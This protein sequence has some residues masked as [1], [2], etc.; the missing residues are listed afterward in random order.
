MN[1]DNRQIGT[2]EAIARLMSFAQITCYY[3]NNINAKT[4]W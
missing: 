4:Q 1:L 3:Y 2:A